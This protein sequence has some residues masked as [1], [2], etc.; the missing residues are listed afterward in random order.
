MIGAMQFDPLIDRYMQH[1]RIEGGLSH[2]TIAAYRRDLKKLQ[3]YLQ[4]NE[5][6]SIGRV[7]PDLLRGFLASLQS[8]GLAQVSS[9]RCLS[10]VRGWF[11]YLRGEHLVDHN[12]SVELA[13]GFRGLRL[14]KTLSQPDVGAI[15]DLPPRAQ[16][17]D[18]RDRAMME[19][20]YATGLRVSELISVEWS[21]VNV[22]VGYLRVTGKGNKQ[23]V[24]PMGE[25]ARLLLQQYTEQVRPSLLKRR[26]S[27]FLFVSRRGT[28][29][30]RQAFWKMLRL[31]AK[32]AGFAGSIS[33]HMLRHSFATHMLEG[34]ADLRSV[35]ALL[36]HANIATTQI[37]THVERERLKHVHET[38]FPRRIA[39]KTIRRA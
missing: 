38:Y 29:L 22:D 4:Q 26:S 18:H 1:L 30:T 12:P 11:R 32:R 37:Y 2:H 36:G 14:P 13:A 3:G 20:L 6:V 19:V 5:V 17:E 9:A 28:P 8:T 33:P 15:L 23:R 27:R 24:V 21:D 31:R 16:L 7:T 25:P 35:Q 10:A 34:G 39:R